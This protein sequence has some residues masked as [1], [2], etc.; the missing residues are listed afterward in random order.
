MIWPL[1][2]WP[3]LVALL[4]METGK[5]LAEVMTLTKGHNKPDTEVVATAGHFGRALHK[6][7]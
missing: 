7:V 2:T 4:C 6:A 1:V 3:L 5:R